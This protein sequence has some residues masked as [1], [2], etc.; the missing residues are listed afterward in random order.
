VHLTRKKGSYR[1][2]QNTK[3][4]WGSRVDLTR[5]NLINFE[6]EQLK[7]SYTGGE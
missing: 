7:A 4:T 2:L 5:T 1:L 6:E 3:Y